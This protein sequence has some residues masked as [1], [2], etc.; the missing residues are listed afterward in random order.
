MI[1]AIG[2][3][4]RTQIEALLGARV[5]LDLEVKAKPGWREDPRVLR[6]LEPME[7]AWAPPDGADGDGDDP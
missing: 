3:A 1:R 6:D 4:A 5:Y 2:T 7:A